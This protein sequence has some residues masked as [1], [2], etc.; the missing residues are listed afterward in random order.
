MIFILWL[1]GIL[2]LTSQNCDAEKYL[3]AYSYLQMNKQVDAEIKE[4]FGKVVK[5]KKG[6]NFT[7][8]IDP[9][10]QPLTLTGFNSVSDSISVSELRK[11]EFGDLPVEVTQFSNCEDFEVIL[12]LTFSVLNEDYLTVEISLRELNPLGGSSLG[13]SIKFLLR[14]DSKNLLTELKS[15]V[16]Y[17]G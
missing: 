2:P 14:F 15:V 12:N 5:L 9:I 7:Y 1:S 16:Y 11:I 17:N 3:M 10:L 6:S 8:C 4:V 13:P